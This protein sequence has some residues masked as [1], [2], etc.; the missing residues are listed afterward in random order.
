ML[1][2]HSDAL[3][4]DFSL[5]LETALYLSLGWGLANVPS[6]DVMPL[7]V[8]VKPCATSAAHNLV[9]SN[10]CLVP[11]LGSLSIIL[12]LPVGFPDVQ[13]LSDSRRQLVTAL[14]HA[15]QLTEFTRNP[16]G[17]LKSRDSCLLSTWNIQILTTL[18]P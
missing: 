6:D 10:I 12:S 16:S 4:S 8:P 3:Q 7:L 18:S 1:S 2:T 14:T 13:D 9:L 17:F 11:S 15:D 5:S